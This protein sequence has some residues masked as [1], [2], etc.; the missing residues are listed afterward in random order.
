MTAFASHV[1]ITVPVVH[2]HMHI[3]FP[4]TRDRP[5]T[6]AST[7]TTHNIRKIRKNMTRRD[8]NPQSQQVSGDRPTH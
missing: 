4:W 5:V 1:A 2:G 7:C 3:R 6:Q 8:S